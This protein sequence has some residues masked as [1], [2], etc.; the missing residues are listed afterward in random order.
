M[1]AD[2]GGRSGG[3]RWELN[4]LSPRW[5]GWKYERGTSSFRG[6]S[7][8]FNPLTIFGLPFEALMTISSNDHLRLF[9]ASVRDA[10]MILSLPILYPSI[11]LYV[12]FF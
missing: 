9:W 6:H 3:S 1:A 12:C 4:F 7:L 10:L 2:F 5:A 8:I 11:F